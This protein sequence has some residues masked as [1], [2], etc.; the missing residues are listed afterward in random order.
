MLHDSLGQLH[1]QRCLPAGKQHRAA[2]A[3]GA[4]CKATPGEPP[5]CA[6]TLTGTLTTDV[7]GWDFT[8]P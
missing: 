5:P 7:L 1:T 2:Y 4:D 6:E 3:K 8:P